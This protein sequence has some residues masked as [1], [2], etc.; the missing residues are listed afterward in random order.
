MAAGV[1]RWLDASLASMVAGSRAP[2]SKPR[3]P[4][5][6]AVFGETPG[7]VDL[8]RAVAH[9]RSS[10]LNTMARVSIFAGQNSP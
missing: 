9:W 4:A 1:G 8:A 5:W 3:A 7:V 2:S 6:A 10:E